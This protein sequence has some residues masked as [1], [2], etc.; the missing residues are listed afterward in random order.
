[1]RLAV[2]SIVALHAV[3]FGGLL[4]QGCKPR[5]PE[6]DAL[7]GLPPS[8]L[9]TNT[10]LPPL[11]N[12]AP[13]SWETRQ[14]PTNVQYQD[15]YPQSTNP[16]Q[17][18]AWTPYTP[19]ADI[20]ATPAPGQATAGT[21]YTIKAGDIP[22]SIARAH[23]ISLSALMNANPGLE[24]RKLKIGKKLVI[25]AAPAVP[26]ST[27]GAG[28]RTVPDVE[29]GRIHVVKSGENL[30]RIARQYGITVKELR[31]ANNLRTDRINAGAKLK[32]P[33]ANAPAPAPA[34]AA[35]DMYNPTPPA[36]VPG[37][38]PTPVR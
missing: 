22:A 28:T 23:G 5:T 10:D 21:E 30:I 17:P 31:G 16:S 26:G 38:Y 9:A 29:A 15:T 36:P 32:I 2:I 4:F 6:P 1:M 13:Y 37:T 33:A 19:Q 34:P 14:S 24:P 20:A 35:P 25:P 27:T 3:F 18:A 12:Q 11:T 7:T 8:S